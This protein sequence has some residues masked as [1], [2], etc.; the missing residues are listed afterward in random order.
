MQVLVASGFK[1]VSLGV[2]STYEN[3]LLCNHRRKLTSKAMR[4]SISMLHENGVGTVNL[5]MMYGL[6]V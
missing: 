2:Q 3:V 6:K 1:R 4:N 5:D